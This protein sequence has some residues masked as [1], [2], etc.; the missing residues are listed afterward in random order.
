MSIKDHER[1]SKRRSI[2]SEPQIVYVCKGEIER[3]I[4]RER[5]QK[6]EEALLKYMI[7]KRIHKKI[8]RLCA[9]S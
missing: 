4:E 8:S 9:A 2:H 1:E 6:R 3:Q 7:K 5:D